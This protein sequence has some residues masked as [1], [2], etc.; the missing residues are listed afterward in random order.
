MVGMFSESQGNRSVFQS[1]LKLYLQN[2]QNLQVLPESWDPPGPTYP[3]TKSFTPSRTSANMVPTLGQPAKKEGYCP[4]TSPPPVGQWLTFCSIKS[5]PIYTLSLFFFFLFRLSFFA[6]ET[7]WFWSQN[8]CLF[9]KTQI[10]FPLPLRG[11]LVSS[12]N[13]PGQCLRRPKRESS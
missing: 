11:G 5:L 9:A 6:Q 13:P 12:R 4:L 2:L 3:P 10:P 1:P 7:S 8:L